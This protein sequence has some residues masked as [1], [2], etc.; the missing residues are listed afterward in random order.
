LINAEDLVPQGL[1]GLKFGWR[2]RKPDLQRSGPARSENRARLGRGN[3]EGRLYK[4][5]VNSRTVSSFA[6][7][8]VVVWHDVAGLEQGGNT[9]SCHHLHAEER[10]QNEHAKHGRPSPDDRCKAAAI[11]GRKIE[12]WR[13]GRSPGE[14]R[15]QSFRLSRT[16]REMPMV[17]GFDD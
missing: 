6:V 2:G 8:P 12:K 11:V 10:N 3:G 13:H 7:A 15:C 16:K 5:D 17:H 9:M 14:G 4:H 1:S